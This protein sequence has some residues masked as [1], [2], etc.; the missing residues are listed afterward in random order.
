MTSQL[1]SKA[2]VIELHIDFT[3]W[4]LDWVHTW[5]I[6][7]CKFV[8]KAPYWNSLWQGNSDH[9]NVLQAQC[10]PTVLCQSLI[11]FTCSVLGIS[12]YCIY[13]SPL[14]FISKLLNFT[15][16]WDLKLISSS[17][18]HLVM[19]IK[20]IAN[21]EWTHDWIVNNCATHE[22]PSIH[23][24]IMNR[25]INDRRM[26]G[27]NGKH[28]RIEFNWACFLGKGNTSWRLT[29]WK[30]KLNEIFILRMGISLIDV[31]RKGKL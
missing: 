29:F 4:R 23:C 13:G 9:W 31:L 2:Q 18:V 15:S 25:E 8:R 10:S 6:I 14:Y 28:C 24:D 21:S 1:L 5:H 27:G 11:Q 16:I 19:Y 30:K 12:K 26:H 20:L 17:K 22:C 3:T 7:I